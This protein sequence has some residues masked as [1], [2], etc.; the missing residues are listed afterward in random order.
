MAD[1]RVQPAL[2]EQECR[3]LV[4]RIV[5]S[6]EFRRAHRLKAFLSY[7]VDRKLAG[8][9][10]E[11]TEVL[12]GRSVFGRSSSYNPAED[13]IVRTEARILRQRL[14]RYFAGEGLDEPVLLEI[15][16]GGYAPVFRSRPDPGPAV[17]QPVSAPVTNRRIW[18]LGAAGALVGSA[19]FWRGFGS[20]LHPSLASNP[21]SLPLPGLIEFEASDPELVAGLE[22][23]KQHALGYAYSGDAVG[24]WYDSTAGTRYAFCMRDTSHQSVGAAVLGLSG[25][26]RNMLARFAASI[27]ESRDWCGFWEINKDGFPAP[28]DY[29]DDANFWYCLPANF[30]V[31]RACYREF[32]WTGDRTYFDAV[33]SNFYDRTVTSYVG[34]W[35]RDRDGL[36]ESS[37]QAGR[38]GIPSYFQHL[39]RP[40]TGADLVSA[41]YCG[42]ETYASIQRFKGAQGSLSEKLALE[43]TAKARA[44]R[45]RFNSD[46]W[47]PADRRFYPAI[48]PDHS[49]CREPI[50]GINAHILW[51]GIAEPGSKRDAILDAL[52]IDQTEFPQIRSYLPEL[53]FRHG[54]SESAY[55]LLLEIM[56]P[57][58]PA[59]GMP[60]IVYAVLGAVAAGL[61]GICPDASQRTLETAPRLPKTLAWIKLV[62]VPVLGNEVTVRHDGSRRTTL[63]NHAGPLFRWRVRFPSYPEGGQILVDNAPAPAIVDGESV[64]ALVSLSPGQTR[65]ARYVPKG[66]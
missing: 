46:W 29:Q 14:E 49:Y 28:V 45:T 5:A 23:A 4:E 8:C 42:Y 48:L 9:S 34:A 17:L 32:L 15:P 25:H 22:W 11:L 31:M 50:D 10:E 27:S 39:P 62:R 16:K 24:K 65:I 61:M 43:Y 19:A 2:G 12:V 52:E 51:F 30:D 26:T 47:D 57:D 7:V 58:S 55:R 35:D 33:F 60:E 13:S 1:T 64:S 18:L 20:R 53:L 66:G 21:P 3:A 38:R 59:R 54:R 36:M 56:R 44:L 41:Q 63:T 40:L 37:P 6:K